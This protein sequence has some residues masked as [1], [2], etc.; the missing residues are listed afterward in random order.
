M[1]ANYSLIGDCLWHILLP[2]QA[3]NGASQL[4]NLTQNISNINR[5]GQVGENICHDFLFHLLHL[6]AMF[7]F[8][9]QLIMSKTIA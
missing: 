2:S 7:L 8:R 9:Q 4:L 5:Q 3:I 6:S 1:D